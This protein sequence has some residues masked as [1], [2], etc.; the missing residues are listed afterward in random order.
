MVD[1]VSA[2]HSGRYGEEMTSILPIHFPR[3]C[4][5]KEGFVHQKSRL[6]GIAGPLAA[7][8]AFGNLMH[9]RHQ[10]VEQSVFHLLVAGSPLLQQLRD[11][12]RVGSHSVPAFRAQ[13]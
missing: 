8:T 2:H 3:L 1:Q 5:A 6:E 10:Q 9:L 11:F 12:A 4:Q 7:E 13:L